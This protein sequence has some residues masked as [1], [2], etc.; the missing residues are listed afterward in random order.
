MLRIDAESLESIRLAW[1]RFDESSYAFK[2]TSSRI[3]KDIENRSIE[4]WI[5]DVNMEIEE[6]AIT[7]MAVG[8][9][10]M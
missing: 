2:L 5:H 1:V 10:A 6:L 9:I 7:R 8:F 4:L 3:D